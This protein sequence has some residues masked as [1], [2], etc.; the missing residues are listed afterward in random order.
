MAFHA[1]YKLPNMLLIAYYR[2][3]PRNLPHGIRM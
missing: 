1:A 2:P 3:M